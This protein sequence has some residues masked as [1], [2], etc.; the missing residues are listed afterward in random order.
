MVITLTGVE[1]ETAIQ[2]YLLARGLKEGGTFQIRVIGG[3][4]I[5]GKQN[6]STAEVH[7]TYPRET[8]LEQVSTTY[9]ERKEELPKEDPYEEEPEVLAE[10]PADK[11]SGL[12]ASFSKIQEPIE[13]EAGEEEAPV[14]AEVKPMPN[15]FR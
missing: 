3:R 14:L 11:P 10:E 12:F 4:N 9:T 8:P 6:M 7:V 5:R 1:L 13:D 15:L 2:E